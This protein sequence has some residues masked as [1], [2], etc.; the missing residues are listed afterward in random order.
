MQETRR[1]ILEILKT[2]YEATVDEVVDALRELRRDEITAVTVRHH[3]KVLQE[4]GLIDSGR[5][6]HRPTP[7]RPQY[8]Y[9]LTDRG[10]SFFPNNYQRL[11]A[12]LLEQVEKHY[13]LNGVNVI[14]EGVASQMAANAAIPDS[15]MDKR[16][17]A[18]VAYLSHHG[19]EARWE[20]A[21]QGYILYMTN[22]PYSQLSHETDALC[23]MDMRLI[24]SMLGV[25]PRLLSRIA[26][27]EDT[28]SYFVPAAAS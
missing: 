1:K 13:T 18:V 8:V 20:N 9:R 19:Y 21:D 12:N 16:L 7:G 2:R 11:A 15:A 26:T 27:G 6:R 3:L 28:C 14:L 24:S 17:D 4:E 25:V 5:M 23:R 22:C 10:A